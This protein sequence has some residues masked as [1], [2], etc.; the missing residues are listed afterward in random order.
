MTRKSEVRRERNDSGGRRRQITFSSFL[1]PLTRMSSLLVGSF[2]CSAALKS[3]SYVYPKPS[4]RASAD[5]TTSVFVLA[6]IRPS[7]SEKA[8]V[9]RQSRGE[10]TSRCNRVTC[11]RDNCGLSMVCPC[12]AFLNRM[13]RVQEDFLAHYHI[14]R[15]LRFSSLPA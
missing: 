15:R 8:P 2:L 9:V 12:V 6:P 4:L 14:D 3:T 10:K 5:R 11:C 13:C 1:R 7:G